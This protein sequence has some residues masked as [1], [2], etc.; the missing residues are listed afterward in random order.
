MNE[1]LEQLSLDNTFFVEFGIFVV[2]FFLISNI[3]FK[4]FLKLFQARFQKT[5]AD[6]ETAEKLLRQAE[7]KLQEYKKILHE[8]RLLAKADYEKILSETRKIEAELLAHAKDEARKMTQE[9]LESIDKQRIELKKQ[10]S[11]DV[12][13]LAQNISERLLSRKV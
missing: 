13:S 9:T 1:V 8:E 3:Y 11:S 2:L 5:I 10:L 6:K 7:A 4:P 12:E